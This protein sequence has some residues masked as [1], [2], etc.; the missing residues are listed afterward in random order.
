MQVMKG[1]LDASGVTT[2]SERRHIVVNTICYS[3]SHGFAVSKSGVWS[4][5]LIFTGR[6]T[7]CVE[8]AR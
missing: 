4:S 7:D 3:I 5:I 6:E 1:A 8:A 2:Q